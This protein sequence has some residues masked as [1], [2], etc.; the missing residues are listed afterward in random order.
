M[1]RKNKKKTINIIIT[2]MRN[3]LV[4]I[5]LLLLFVFLNSCVMEEG[6]TTLTANILEHPRGGYNVNTLTSQIG[7]KRIF[8]KPRGFPTPS[9]SP[10]VIRVEVRWWWDNYYRTNRELVKTDVYSVSSD[11]EILSARLFAGDGY[12]FLNNYWLEISWS[13]SNGEH[14]LNSN[15]AFCAY[16]NS[17]LDSI[18]KQK[19]YIE[20][21]QI[22][23]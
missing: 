20:N 8:K 14:T 4:S 12:I 23:D 16:Q 11:S 1:V 17:K 9:G 18:D 19:V 2:I 3:L 6:K 22:V 15:V 7:L 10:D 21:D 13:D 5:F